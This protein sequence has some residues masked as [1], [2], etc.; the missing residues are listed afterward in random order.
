[1]KSLRSLP[2]RNLL[3]RKGRTA[4]LT[5]LVLVLSLCVS[6]GSLLLQSLSSGMSSLEARLGAD[7]IVV[8]SSAKSKMNVNEILLNGTTGYFYMPRERYEQI[9]SV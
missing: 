5:A 7:I 1:M 6:G 8:P 4:L 2:L 3:H 9:L